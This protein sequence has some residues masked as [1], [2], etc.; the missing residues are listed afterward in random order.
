MEEEFGNI[1]LKALFSIYIMNDTGDHI[2]GKWTIYFLLNRGSFV[3]RDPRKFKKTTT[4][5]FG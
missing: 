3:R 2:P 4:G 5:F 1:T